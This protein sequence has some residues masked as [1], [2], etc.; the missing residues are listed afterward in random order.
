MGGAPASDQELSGREGWGQCPEEEGFE[1]S[2][3]P[4]NNW[5]L[6]G[7]IHGW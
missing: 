6:L 2:P 5:D 7:E 4:F 1:Y 3:V